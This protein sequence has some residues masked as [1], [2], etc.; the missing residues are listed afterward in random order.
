M[1][2]PSDREALYAWHASALKALA[3]GKAEDLIQLTRSKWLKC[4]PIVEDEPQ[5]GYFK[6]R[7]RRYAVLVPSRIFMRSVVDE[8]G[9]LVQDEE[10]VCEIGDTPFDVIEAWIKLCIRPITL[11][12]YQYLMAVREW[13]RASAPDQ[14]QAKD[15]AAV[16]W[17]TVKI[18]EIP[19][20]PTPAKR[21]R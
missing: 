10:L 6:A 1:R 14:P 18:P 2:Q 13:A 5:C 17:M 4:P 8:L 20:T 16:D 15:G 9:E 7:V 11:G 21:K 3:D 19:A 12:E